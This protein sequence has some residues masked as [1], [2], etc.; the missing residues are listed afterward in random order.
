MTDHGN[1]FM[2]NI[3]KNNFSMKIS[4]NINTCFYKEATQM[5]TKDDNHFIAQKK[6]NNKKMTR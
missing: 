5:V 4:K 6:L 3:I 2:K 1:V